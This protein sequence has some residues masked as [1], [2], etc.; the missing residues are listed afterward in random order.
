MESTMMVFSLNTAG[1]EGTD[2]SQASRGVRLKHIVERVIQACKKGIVICLQEVHV[3]WLDKFRQIFSQTK[4]VMHECLSNKRIDVYLVTAH[5][6]HLKATPQAIEIPNGSDQYA[7]A[8]DIAGTIITNVHFAVNKQFRMEHTVTLIR[9][10]KGIPGK[11]IVVGDMNL[12]GDWGGAEQLALFQEAGF[13][14]LT[15]VQHMPDPTRTAMEYFHPYPSDP[16]LKKENLAEIIQKSILLDAAMTFGI[17]QKIKTVVAFLPD[18]ASDHP[19]I[20]LTF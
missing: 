7:L 1:F 15:H 5:S 14:D 13:S 19:S 6:E 4:Y 12:M 18:H 8:L 3:S 10:L 11:H 16:V 20:E 2:A 17:D 9:S